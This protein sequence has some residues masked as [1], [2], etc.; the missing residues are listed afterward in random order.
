MAIG[1]DDDGSYG[2]AMATNRERMLAGEWYRVADDAELAAMV[3]RRQQLCSVINAIDASDELVAA[4]LSSLLGSIG[5]GSVIRPPFRCDY[6]SHI[7]LGDGVFVNFGAVFL[8]CGLVTI[9]DATQVGP[10]VQLLTPDHP[11]DAERR[12]AG[13]EAAHPITIGANVWIGGG[14]IVGPGVTI[15]DDA[16]VGAGAVVVR[17]VPA[18]ATVVGNP[19]RPLPPRR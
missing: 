3:E 17:D 5:P 16:I 6:G 1:R 15:G 12:R 7:S 11:R 19:A 13:W 8:D 10:N 9:G 18:G 4:T 2:G 14:A